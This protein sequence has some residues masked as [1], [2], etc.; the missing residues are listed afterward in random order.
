MR[1]AYLKKA[2]GGATTQKYQKHTQNHDVF[3]MDAP[4]GVPGVSKK[5]T[6]LKDQ[7]LDV[8]LR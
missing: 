7:Y 5:H 2:V 1:L 6:E 3:T 4:S 8:F